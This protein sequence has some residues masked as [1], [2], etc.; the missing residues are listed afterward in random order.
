MFVGCTFRKGPFRKIATLSS[1]TLL[2]KNMNCVGLHFTKSESNQRNARKLL[3]GEKS[4]WRLKSGGLSGGW[5]CRGNESTSC[6]QQL[7]L[8]LSALKIPLHS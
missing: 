5:K 4:G 7:V 1:P 3:G 8:K 6:S 2:S